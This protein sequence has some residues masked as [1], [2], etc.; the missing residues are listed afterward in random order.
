MPKTRPAT[1]RSEIDGIG[2]RGLARLLKAVLAGAVLADAASGGAAADDTVP[3]V[4]AGGRTVVVAQTIL[5]AATRAGLLRV[6]DRRLVATAQTEPCLRRALAAPD[7]AFLEQHRDV[8]ETL[9]EGPEGPARLSV[10]RLE[11]PLSTVARLKERDGK[12][13]LPQEAISAGERLHADFTRAHLQP[14]LT[15]I[16]APPLPG[17]SGKAPARGDL[18][19][20]ALAARTRVRAA[21]EAMGP[22][23]SGV[24]L[25]ICCFEKGLETV[26]TGTPVAGP[27]RQGD[28]ARRAHGAGPPLCAAA[29][30]DAPQPCLGRAGLS[31]D[32]LPPEPKLIGF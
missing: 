30:R 9:R 15:M 17:G 14:R 23:L 32:A 11:S 26:E 24:A 8:Q 5:A 1:P 25:D 2:G 7:E 20:S 10:N 12:P 3:L 22:E 6:E 21:V 19:D 28:A 31:A 13:F 27:L 16:Y 18:S 29:K 4:C